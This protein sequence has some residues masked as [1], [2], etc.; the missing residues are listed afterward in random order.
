MALCMRCTTL[1][2]SKHIPEEFCSPTR[3]IQIHCHL[4]LVVQYRGVELITSS[5]V[6]VPGRGR[7]EKLKEYF[8]LCL[9]ASLPCGPL[10]DFCSSLLI[11]LPSFTV[12]YGVFGLFSLVL[13]LLP[14][15]RGSVSIKG[16]ALF[17]C[18]PTLSR[19][20]SVPP[21]QVLSS[22]KP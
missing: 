9:Q 1:E 11:G 19:V 4:L 20:L 3:N 13:K 6:F 17:T 5:A 2:G 22:Q 12:N 16:R 18:F 8:H 21:L 7:L 14:V 10:P 15:V